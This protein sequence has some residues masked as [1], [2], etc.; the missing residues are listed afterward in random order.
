LPYSFIFFFEI[1]SGF[2]ANAPAAKDWTASDD[3]ES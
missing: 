3:G 2:R 1:N